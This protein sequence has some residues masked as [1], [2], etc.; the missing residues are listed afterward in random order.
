MKIYI[1]RKEKEEETKMNLWDAFTNHLDSI[2]F[3]GA[4]D[5]LDKQT[6]AFEY[7]NFKACY[8]P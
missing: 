1:K 2:Y 3:P 6:L 4:T 8:I 5:S 7:E